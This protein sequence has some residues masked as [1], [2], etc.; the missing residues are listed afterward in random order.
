V[1]P[2]A[3][4]FAKE[5]LDNL[6]D[7]RSVTMALFF[8]LLGPILFAV[9]I[10]LSVREARGFED[11]PLQLPVAGAERAPHLM[12]W[13]REAG[14]EP[15]EAPADPERAVRAGDVELVL[16]VPPEFGER[17]REGRPGPLRLV[18]DESRR[19]GQAAVGRAKRLLEGWSRQTGALRLVA[20]GIHPSVPEAA[21]LEVV[22]LST[23]ES[24]AGLIFMMLPYFLMLPLFIGGMY[25]A[26]DITAGER[27][28]A[29]LEPLLLQPVPRSAVALA[30]IAAT[31]LFSA[32]AL[33]ET[34]V[35]MG[36][37]PRFMPLERLGFFV[38]LGPAV[39]ARTG[40]LFLPLAL[41]MSALMVLVAARARGYRAAQAS[42]SFLMLVPV[43]PTVFLM[44][45]PVKLQPWMLVVPTLGEQLL[46]GRLVRGETV[47][48]AHFALTMGSALLY[49]AALSALA[50]AM[51]RSE[52]LIFGR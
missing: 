40:L 20:R 2:F 4:I 51:F 16:V 46:V 24:R 17:L 35:A 21:A 52:K 22:D 13:L 23:P 18:V 36:I 44:M 42:L 38:R 11:R 3:T 41:L 47:P 8:P 1:S 14:A 9:S 39:L 29:S 25:V 43:L 19:S 32:V 33:A 30:K 15:V 10:S 28:R 5:V 37:L 50:V 49:A 6:R 26:I 45:L 31:A 27:E 48:A 34:V 7:R 12:A